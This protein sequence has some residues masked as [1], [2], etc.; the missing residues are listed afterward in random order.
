MTTKQSCFISVANDL[1]RSNVI[2]LAKLKDNLPEKYTCTNRYA[3]THPHRDTCNCQYKSSAALLEGVKN[4]CMSVNK[5]WILRWFYRISEGRVRQCTFYEHDGESSAR[6]IFLLPKHMVTHTHTHT[7]WKEFASTRSSLAGTVGSFSS[8]VARRGPKSAPKI[9]M[10]GN[11]EKRFL[12]WI[13]PSVNHCWRNHITARENKI[14]VYSPTATAHC[15][16]CIP[17]TTKRTQ[18][19]P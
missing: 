8:C 13:N 15:L 11:A 6:A 17:M 19:Q 18:Q 12:T 10:L 3:W 5:M 2:Q 9:E 16:S 4:S 7:S 14:M 1:A